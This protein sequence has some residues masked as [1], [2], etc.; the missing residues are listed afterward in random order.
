[1]LN[2]IAYTTKQ[3]RAFSTKQGIQ[4]KKALLLPSKIPIFPF[5]SH[6]SVISDDDKDTIRK[7]GFQNAVMSVENQYLDT[8]DEY[9]L[10]II[11]RAKEQV[12]KVIEQVQEE[13]DGKTTSK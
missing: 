9:D 8:I 6:V 2:R 13:N 12:V 11:K 1:M 5:Q 7:L 3:F 10:E 4:T